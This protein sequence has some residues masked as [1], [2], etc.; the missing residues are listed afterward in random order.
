[1]PGDAG[2]VER[3][4]VAT[5]EVGQQ[6][7]GEV[8][9]VVGERVAHV[10]GHGVERTGTGG[11]PGGHRRRGRG[12]ARSGCHAEPGGGVGRTCTTVVGP[13]PP[14]EHSHRTAE[15]G[16]GMR[17]RGWVAEH[18]V[19]HQACRSGERGGASA[20]HHRAARAT[21]AS[22]SPTTPAAPSTSP[23][24]PPRRRWASTATAPAPATSA[25]AAT[26]TAIVPS[27]TRS[28]AVSRVPVAPT[29]T[30]EPPRNAEA[31]PPSARA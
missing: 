31:R 18:L 14:L 28:T 6:L 21:S 2:G 20:G 17:G 10:E 25:T 9:V 29:A 15:P 22:V 23:V 4:G 1:R 13:P 27:G 19:E 3:V 8:E 26:S 7:P 12:E 16:D 24:T 30:G 5:D 11:D